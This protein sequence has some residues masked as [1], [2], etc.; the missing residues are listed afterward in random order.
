MGHLPDFLSLPI[1]DVPMV[2]WLVFIT[3]ILGLLVF[4]LR[5][6]NRKDHEPKLQESLR[7]TLLYAFVA[8]CFGIWVWTERGSGDGLDFFTAYLVEMSLSL[9]NIFVMSL[10]F[11]YF[12]VPPKYQHRVL[13]WGILGVVF[14][15][16]VMIGAGSALLHN[17]S[18]VLL[19]FA[20]FLIFTGI[21]LL[22]STG[23]HSVMQENKAVAFLKKHVPVTTTIDGNRF[24]VREKHLVHGRLVLHATPLL[25][26]LITIECADVVFAFD[27]IPAVFAI[28]TDTFIVYTSNLFAVVGLR[29]M[30]F[31]LIAIIHRFSYMNYALSLILIVI[32]LKAFYAHFFDKVPSWLSLGLT[33]GILLGGFLFSFQK[34]RKLEAKKA[35]T[36]G[37][38]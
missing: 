27:S 1:L 26:A 12:H 33:L 4:D 2:F 35:R 36:Q 20:A 32:G 37:T 21:K 23:G 24:L 28:T 18:W 5:F 17:F 29:A 14:F 19:I 30:Y 15:R 6:L 10:V 8:L 22:F 38:K 9:D 31:V 3:L 13:F 34:T 16:A 25:L 11:T 7:L